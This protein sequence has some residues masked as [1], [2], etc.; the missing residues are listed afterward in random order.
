MKI[1]KI[2]LSIVG[3]V[4]TLLFLNACTS[5]KRPIPGS[6]EQ[7]AAKK[8]PDFTQKEI[9]TSDGHT[10]KYEGSNGS[11]FVRS[12][13][14]GKKDGI[15]ALYQHGVLYAEKSYTEGVLDGWSINYYYPF[16][17]SKTYYVNGKKHGVVTK[18]CDDGEKLKL[19]EHYSHGQLDGL[20]E[21]WSC[22]GKHY[23]ERS[24]EYKNGKKDGVEKVYDNINYKDGSLYSSIEYKNGKKHGVS[25]VYHSKGK[26]CCLNTYKNG[27]L[28]GESK[29]WDHTGKLTKES[30]YRNGREFDMNG[31]FIPKI[32]EKS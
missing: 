8:A 6:G 28:E 18:W 10:I 24:T 21:A 25:K 17:A 26:L 27:I 20:S 9:L 1:L 2:V 22:E 16:T 23:L 31:N 4:V 19:R 11:G 5:N 3:L 32:K 13:K 14:N 30:V 15:T 29:F 7:T 12:Y